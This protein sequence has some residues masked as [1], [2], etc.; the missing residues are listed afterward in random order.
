MQH[1]SRPRNNSR[2]YYRNLLTFNVNVRVAPASGA[3]AA[4]E[5]ARAHGRAYV[6][7]MVDAVSRVPGVEAVATVQEGVPLYF[8]VALAGVFA[9]M[10]I[11]GPLRKFHIAWGLALIGYFFVIMLTANVRPRFRIVFEPFW[12]L[13]IALLTDAAIQGIKRIAR[14]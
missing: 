14:R 6:D 5:E 9:A 4:F 7:R 11:P 3:A 12:F 1:P 13:Y 10:F 8:L 2:N